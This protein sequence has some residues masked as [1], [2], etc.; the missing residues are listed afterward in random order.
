MSSTGTDSQRRAEPASE[1]TGDFAAHNTASDAPV[2][3]PTETAAQP[4]PLLSLLRPPQLE[5][6]N[7]RGDYA[8]TR[9]KVLRSIPTLKTINGKP[10]ADFWKAIDAGE[11]PQPG[12]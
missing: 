4:D 2:V 7:L 6:I 10:A 8:P 9:I 11:K 5:C 3:V 1:P 12:G